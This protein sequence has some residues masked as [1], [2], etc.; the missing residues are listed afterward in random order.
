MREQT[1]K[2]LLAIPMKDPSRAKS[3]LGIELSPSERANLA[4]H[5]FRNVVD[6]VKDAC[7]ERP[8]RSVDIAV[9]SNSATIQKM[10]STMDLKWINDG[11]AGN[12]SAAITCAAHVATQDRYANLCILPGDLADPSVSDVCCLI[13][14]ASEAFNAAICP[15][16]DMGTNALLL[17]L[18]SPIAFHYGERS[19]HHHYRALVDAG[20]MTTILP[21]TSLRRDVD[22]IQ[23]WHAFRQSQPD[24][25]A[26]SER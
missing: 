22:T 5:L 24:A 26:W 9:I 2:L 21:L 13:D 7:K 1:G 3:R 17:P 4:I 14:H 8:G 6:C 12:L 10:C 15:S 19:F 20:L 16:K 23:D 11:N 18:P 25:F